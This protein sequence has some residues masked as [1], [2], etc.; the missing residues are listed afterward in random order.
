M[1]WLERHL[2][3]PIAAATGVVR[4]STVSRYSRRAF[5]TLLGVAAI[6]RPLR[7][8]G[9]VYDVCASEEVPTSCDDVYNNCVGAGGTWRGCEDCQVVSCFSWCE[10]TDCDRAVCCIIFT[11]R[12]Y[13]NPLDYIFACWEEGLEHS[14]EE[15][16]EGCD[17]LQDLRNTN[18]IAGI[19]PTIPRQVAT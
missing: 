18:S 13:I 10:V 11:C 8:E 14:V 12:C 3:V 6:G 1:K 4:D 9:L 15:C 17:E 19:V 5:A 16:E 2:M 7:A